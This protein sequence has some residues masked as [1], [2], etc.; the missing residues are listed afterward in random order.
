MR[1]IHRGLTIDMEDDDPRVPIFEA[2]LFGRA[3]PP[4]HPAPGPETVV[5]QP[6]Q[7]CWASLPHRQRQELV[8]LTQGAWPAAALEKALKID[9]ALLRAQHA[10]IHR[11]G[12]HYG[13][14]LKVL[15]FGRVRTKRRYELSLEATHFIKR[16]AGA[17]VPASARGGG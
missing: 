6:W 5:P 2:V 16:L 4:P 9:H 1:V 17:P 8:L 3:L 15:S 12:R 11:A 13:I 7:A 14:D 10:R